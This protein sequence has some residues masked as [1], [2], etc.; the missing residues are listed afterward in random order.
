L[1]NDLRASLRSCPTPALGFVL[2]DASQS[3]PTSDYD[4][5]R[6]LPTDTASQPPLRRVNLP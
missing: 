1:L 5:V 6:D 3:E 2:N 4:G